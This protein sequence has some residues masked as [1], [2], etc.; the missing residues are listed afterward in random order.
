MGRLT[1]AVRVR[2]PVCEP[3]LDSNVAT[4]SPQKT[5]VNV[6][7]DNVILNEATPKH[8]IF[9]K[10][11]RSRQF[12]FDQCFDSAKSQE[13]IFQILG[14]TVLDSL[15]VVGQNCSVVAYG[16]TGSGKTFTMLGEPFQPGFIPQFCN[17]LIDSQANCSVSFYEIYNEKVF[18]LLSDCRKA[19]SVRQHPSDGP[20]VLGLQRQALKSSDDLKRLL[21]IGIESRTTAKTVSHHS[22][23]RSHAVFTI[24]LNEDKGPKLHLVDLAGSERPHHHASKLEIRESAHINRSLA[25]LGNVILCLSC[26]SSARNGSKFAPYRDSALTWLLRDSLGGRAQTVMIATISPEARFYNETL[27]TLRYANRARSI[28]S[29]T[30]DSENRGGRHGVDDAIEAELRREIDRLRVAL[31]DRLN[32]HRPPELDHRFKV[33]HCIRNAEGQPYVVRYDSNTRSCMTSPLPV[34]HSDDVPVI[35]RSKSVALSPIM[36]QSPRD[37]PRTRA[38]AR[39]CLLMKTPAAPQ[40]PSDDEHVSQ[41]FPSALLLQP[42][43]AVL[44]LLFALSRLVI[45]RLRKK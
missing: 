1:V 44:L 8:G 37:A 16:Q 29:H 21:Q 3:E 43:L 6:T 19:L 14:A 32:H 12:K 15:L 33:C 41:L 9:Q 25:T 10:V 39:G 13:E 20:F 2:P 38:V 36:D 28:F 40:T 45:C 18:D 26:T 31:A 5:T 30:G 24:Y 22:S 17:Y 7:G 27:K 34:V 11:F 23:S 35:K 4:S 42:C